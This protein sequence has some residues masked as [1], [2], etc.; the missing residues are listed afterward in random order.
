MVDPADVEAAIAAA[1]PKETAAPRALAPAALAGRATAEGTARY[2][3]RQPAAQTGYGLLGTTGL[4]CSRVGFGGYRVDDD[5]EVHRAAVAHAL[6]SGCNLVDTSTNYTDGGSER[7]VGAV[8]ADLTKS[9]ALRRDEVIVV[10]K[11][12]YVQGHNLE[13]AKERE[14]A[15]NP[16]PDMVKYADGVWH[17]I[18]PEFLRDQLARSRERLQVETLDACLLHN[19][20][21]YLTDAHERSHGTLEKRRQ[22]LDRRIRDAFSFLEAEVAAGRIAAYGVSSNTCVRPADDPEF[23]S[24]TRM[25]ELAREAGGTGHHFRILQLPMN[26]FEAGA[27]LERNNGP[28]LRRTVLEHAAAEGMAVLANRPL[29][30]MVGEGMQRLADVQEP[31]ATVDLDAQLAVLAGLEDEVPRGDCRPPRSRGGG[32]HPRPVLPMERGPEGRLRA[33]PGH[34][35]LGRPGVAADPPPPPAGPPGARPGALRSAG[36]VLAGVARALP[37][38]AA[39]RA[40]GGPAPGRGPVPRAGHGGRGEAGPAAPR[41]AAARPSPARRSGS[42][43]PSPGERGVER[44][45]PPEYVDD[46]LGILGWPPL[47]DAAAVLRRFR[48]EA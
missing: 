29:N 46:A 16:F 42:S 39:D 17:C 36:R 5:T 9:G 3:A 22:E 23:V 21:Y 12:G 11:A 34:R 48:T 27:A 2:A 20:E 44:R 13:L 43:P 31:A 35:A 45:A 30:A 4:L 6:R 7:L 41:S 33:S 38:R 40:G 1:A 32:R 25:L 19:P 24:L 37:A 18:N 47:P 28:G 26:L 15:G 8:L 10:S 14:A